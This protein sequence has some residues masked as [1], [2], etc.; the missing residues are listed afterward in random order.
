MAHLYFTA[1][2]I[3]TPPED[4]RVSIKYRAGCAYKNVRRAAADEAIALKKAKELP[5][6]SRR[7]AR[8]KIMP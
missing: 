3:F 4:R 6:P 1:D 8:R 7:A 5:T 2:H